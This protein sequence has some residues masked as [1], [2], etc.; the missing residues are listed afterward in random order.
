MMKL[1]ATD[2]SSP[3]GT[4]SYDAQ[5]VYST[6]FPS[7]PVQVSIMVSSKSTAPIINVHEMDLST[8]LTAAARSVSESLDNITMK[9]QHAC[10]NISYTSFFTTVGM[11][12][13]WPAFP[14]LHNITEEILSSVFE[15]TFFNAAGT[16]MLAIASVATCNSQTVTTACVGSDSYCDPV[17]DLQN[18]LLDFVNNALPAS[19][20]GAEL[21]AQVISLP[22]IY[23]ASMAGIDSTMDISTATFPI[24]LLVLGIMLCNARLLLLPILTI[25]GVLGSSI[26][27]VYPIASATQVSTSA[28]SLMIAVA[29][30]MSI[31]YALFILSRLMT[32]L[33]SGH[34]M[35]MAIDITLRT[36]GRTVLVSGSCLTLCFL[37][38]LVVPVSAISTMGLAAAFTV[39][40][41]VLVSLTLTPVLLL[42]FPRFFGSTRLCGLSVDSCCCTKD[43]SCCAK[44]TD[45]CQKMSAAA[46]PCSWWPSRGLWAALGERVQ[47]CPW[48]VLVLVVMIGVAVPFVI[49]LVEFKYT[50]GM[51]PML[52]SSDS[53]TG[54][55]DALQDSFGTGAIFPS[56]LIVVPP[57]KTSMTD[58]KSQWLNA[59]CAA[60]EQIASAVNVDGY[61][62]TLSNFT[63]IMTIGGRCVSDIGE[64]AGGLSAEQIL[65]NLINGAFNFN[66]ADST[67]T[68][69]S[70]SL[71]IDPFS[72]E[73][74]EWIT[75]MRTAM[76]AATQ[77]GSVTVGAFYLTG[78]GPQ[79]MD[80]ANATFAAFPLLIG[81]VVVVIIVVFGL[82]FKSVVVPIRAAITVIWMLV[83]TFGAA[84]FAYP[85]AIFWMSPCIAF[86]VVVGLGLDYDVFF[87][88]TVMENVHRQGMNANEAVL[89]ALESTGNLISAAGVIMAIAF[90]A[91]LLGST[92]ALYQIGFFLVVG[93]IIDCFIST[94]LV[95]PGLMAL[96]PS[97]V[98][99]WPTKPNAEAASGTKVQRTTSAPMMERLVDC[100]P[101]M[102]TFSKQHGKNASPA[103]PPLG[104]AN[105]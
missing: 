24:A 82:A 18:D 16:S 66:N 97:T 87:M 50:I 81:L 48:V 71:K 9:Y 4:A 36:S 26:L 102:R 64:R 25:V 59:S 22:L 55:L 54:A 74:Q 41:A 63:G 17:Q 10:T 5:R 72:T 68:E 73:G 47:R 27:L 28:T 2:I 77:I 98:N 3:S 104:D 32:E 86:A 75:Q 67:A 61:P 13:Q 69:I 95:I 101:I 79:Q 39:V 76:D 21:E 19:A 105:V 96:L 15:E 37:T 29:L 80:A 38:M 1:L 62:M 42:S 53:T 12:P 78:T 20:E 52:P 70:I 11:V 89:A 57:E 7:P 103:E 88:E 92:P 94:K 34:E 6:M 43:T 91:L 100:G 44:E 45:W 65:V 85:G 49:K 58:V 46:T 23:E 84:S 51:L 83:L 56:K 8:P 30:A 99:L 60:L 40:F 93:V 35:A 14:K 31:D 33:R 90:A